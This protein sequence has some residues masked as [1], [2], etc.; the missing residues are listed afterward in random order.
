MIDWDD[1]ARASAF[2]AA[3][4]GSFS[5]AYQCEHVAAGPRRHSVHV[6][7]LILSVS[8][9]GRQVYMNRV[10]WVGATGRVSAC[11]CCTCSSM[12]CERTGH[13]GLPG[14]KTASKIRLT[15][16]W[17]QYMLAKSSE[18]AR[19]GH[20]SR[21][22]RCRQ[23]P[24]HTWGYAEAAMQRHALLTSRPFFGHL[25]PLLA[26]GD[27]L[28]D[29]GCASQSPAS[30][31]RGRTCAITRGSSSPR[32]DGPTSVRPRSRRAARRHPPRRD[33]TFRAACPHGLSQDARPGLMSARPSE[34]N[35]SRG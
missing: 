1:P 28:C 31:T 35:S 11:P 14:S 23:R 15:S 2:T 32:S 9:S 30:K 21:A 12:I 4:F 33:A 24:S 10:P 34:A 16:G 26:Q 6:K 19:V 5:A 22:E 20:P 7:G 17:D 8:P 18:Q 27:A 25:G 13:R 3:P 29:R